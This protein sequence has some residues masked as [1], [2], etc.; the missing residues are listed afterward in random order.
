MK[1]LLK[2]LGTIILTST[3]S[4]NVIACNNQSFKKNLSEKI[5]NSNLDKIYIGQLEKPNKKQI[6]ESIKSKNILASDLNE[7]D[8][9]FEGT[10]T[11]TSAKII[12]TN[13]YKGEVSLN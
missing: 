8:F 1:N 13:D 12:G 3:T 11:S 6:L 4:T 2:I 10:P 7:N 5:K 9:D